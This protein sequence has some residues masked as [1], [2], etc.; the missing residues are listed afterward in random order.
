MQNNQR[1][2]SLDLIRSMALITVVGVHFF[3]N[4]G[5]NEAPFSGGG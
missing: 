4:S 1:S 5:F 3:L 2:F